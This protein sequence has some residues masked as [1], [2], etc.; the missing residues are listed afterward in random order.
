ME[1]IAQYQRMFRFSRRTREF[2]LRPAVLDR[3]IAMGRR[4]P[5]L[6][7]LL[8]EIL[9]GPRDPTDSPGRA[10]ILRLLATG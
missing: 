2:A 3:L 4:R 8:M 5:E 10:E 1:K 6:A 7:T 9:Q